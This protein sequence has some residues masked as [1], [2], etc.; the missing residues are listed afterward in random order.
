MPDSDKDIINNAVQQFINAKLQ[1]RE[2]ALDEFVK[3]YPGY[4]LQIRQKIEKI[5]K[6]DGLFSGLMEADDSDYSEPVTEHDLV[7]QKLGDFE[8]LSLIGAGGMGAVFLARQ[9]SLDR[10]VALKVISDVSGARSKSLERFKREAKVLAKISHPNIV[11]VYEVG[12]QGPYSYFAMEYVQGFSLDKILA[13]I[14]NAPHGDK[15]SKVMLKC[16]ENKTAFS[17]NG[18]AGPERTSGAEIDTD[19]IVAIS[20]MIINIASALDYAHE[21]GILHRDVK[22]SNILI[23]SDG[24]AK[25]VDFG[26]AKAE[27]QQTVTVTGEFFGTPSYVSPEQ[28]RKPETVDCRSDVYSLAA[29]YYECL[30]LHAPFEGSTI[31]ETLTSV[32]SREAVPPKKYCPRLSADLNTVLLHALEKAPED[33]YETA[34]DFADDIQNVLDFKHITAKRPSITRRTYRTLRRNRLK[35]TL[36][37]LIVFVITLSYFVYSAYKQRIEEQRITKVQ[38]LLEDADLLLCQAALNTAPWPSFDN[39]SVAERAYEIYDEILQID[40]GNWWALINRGIARLVSGESVE[41]VLTDLEQAEQVNPDFHVM[42]HLKAKVWVQL[43]K[44]ELKDITLADANDLTAR[45]AYILGFLAL[46]QRNPPENERES[47]RLFSICVEKEPDFYPGLLARAFAGCLTTEE[48]NLAECI[49][50]ANLMPN[51]AFAHLLVGYNLNGTLTLG[52]NRPVEAAKAFSK[53]LELQPWNPKCHVLLATTYGDLGEKEN[54]ERHLLQ[55]YELDKSGSA[56]MSLAF[57]YRTA[58]KDYERCLTFCDEALSKKCSLHERLMILDDKYYALEE[59]GRPEELQQCLI[60]K[61]NLMRS[62]MVRPGVKDNGLLHSDFLRFLYENNRKSEARKFYEETLTKKP[63][64]K[65]TLGNALAQA[66]QNDDKRSDADV[67]YQSLYQEIKSNG[68]NTG[69]LDSLYTINILQNFALF[70]ITCGDPSGGTRVWSELIEKFPNEHRLWKHYGM[71]LLLAQDFDKAI[72]AYNQAFRYVKS[73]DERFELS[74]NLIDALIRSEQYEEAEKELQ[75]LLYRLD[76]LQVYSHDEYINYSNNPDMISEDKAKSVYSRLSDVYVVQKHLADAVSLLEKGL[77]RLPESFEL[78]RKL[79][80]LYTQH[81]NKD[82]AIKAYF[83][84]FNALP[85]STKGRLDLLD[86][87]NA[88]DVVI[89]LTTLLIEAK[90]LDRAK[91]FIFKEQELNRQMQ[92]RMMPAVQPAYETALHLALALIYNKE[93]DIA[94]YL[95]ELNNAAKDQPEL[96]A[97]WQTLTNFY[98]IRGEHETAINTAKRAIK[99]NPDNC[100]YILLLGDI[101]T[102]IGNHESALGAY[103]QAVKVDPNNAFALN[104]LGDSYTRLRRH[105]EAIEA[106]K[107]VLIIDPNSTKAYTN[108]AISYSCLGRHEQAIQ[109]YKQTTQIDPNNFEAYFSLAAQYRGMKRYRE[110]VNSCKRACELTDYKNHI[111]IAVLALFYAESGDFEKAVEY[112]NMA[113]ELVPDK[114]FIGIGVNFNK[115]EGQIKV[116]NLIENTPAH[117]AGLVVGDVIKAVDGQDLA[118]LS[119]ERVADVVRGPIGTEVRLTVKRSGKETIED[120]PLIRERIVNPVITAY[121]LRLDAYKVHKP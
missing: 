71:S 20:K 45:E 87:S 8:I 115:V 59:L 55:A 11:P 42:S 34:S 43:G 76:N 112:Q 64:L 110:A 92:P 95:K 49:T 67:L 47:L 27:T 104:A 81:N 5:Q 61:E 56:A 54:A 74:S 26:L 89:A 46:Q 23:S 117:R 96:F 50:L 107:R 17:E 119:I 24:T 58:K 21:K 25:L 101:N 31:N 15:A 79:A 118:G 77:N 13:S 116:V 80:L 2:R 63:Q 91:E 85:L 82:A 19:Y 53:A 75:A 114:E 6:I 40:E 88:P 3:N 9:I 52:V 37:L 14:R 30:T 99:L 70:K 93:N 22:P 41:D 4:E 97:I 102:N 36:S 105:E 106:Y 62:M 7:G 94:N 51:V 60:Q 10:D 121:K 108:M 48:G 86:L 84:Y 28:I 111:Y 98:L 38:Q 39:M 65:F 16:L 90:Q 57:Y 109:A 103:Q 120:I 33:R 18:M 32:I 66:Y 72:A 73:E 35:V 1:G 29:T 113:I 69:S 68:L 78:Y 83:N 12:E 100:L 44:G